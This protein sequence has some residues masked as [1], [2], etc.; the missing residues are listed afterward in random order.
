MIH[1]KNTLSSAELANLWKV[2]MI[3]NLLI[4]Y[5]I[6]MINT[7][8]DEEVKSVLL[9]AL[10]L[11][12]KCVH[13]IENVYRQE[14]HVLPI[15]FR[16]E[17]MNSEAPALF[18]DNFYLLYIHEMAK[19]GFRIGS[20]VIEIT[21]RNDILDIFYN[22]LNDYKDLYRR[23]L[24]L[25]ISKDLY[26]HSP[27]LPIPQKVDFINEQSYLTGWF[28]KKRP[29]NA[30]EIVRV[31]STADRNAI[32]Q[33]LL[34][35]FSKVVKDEEIKKYIERGIKNTNQIIDDMHQILINENLN[36]TKIY[37]NEVSDSTV[38][39]YSDRLILFHVAQMGAGSI[40]IYGSDLGSVLRKDIG[41][42]YVK[43]MGEA[44]LYGEDGINL[45][46]KKGWIE[47][48]PKNER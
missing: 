26:P 47:E 5:K 32:S 46:I 39:P 1:K 25:L 33:A 20:Q 7:C 45:L 36:M 12:K 34:L 48:P 14:N 22:M 35:G 15:G 8:Q 6:P 42:K 24:N 18:T 13:Q 40:G 43:M 31:H 11:S 16:K 38:S 28:G 27:K 10:E 3:E 29:L 30:E 23:T 4:P 19:L 21:D 44:L 17:D 9:F 41:M 37:D 2:Y